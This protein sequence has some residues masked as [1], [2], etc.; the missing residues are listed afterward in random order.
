[1]GKQGVGKTTLVNILGGT[2]RSSNER[3]E[4]SSHTLYRS[5]INCGNY[6]FSLIDT[7]GTDSFTDLS[8]YAFLLR[9]GLT[10]TIMNTIFIVVRYDSRFD[11]MVDSYF[12]VEQLVKHNMDKIIV[13]ISFG[14]QSKNPE[15]SFT[16]ICQLFEEECPNVSNLI[17]YSERSPNIQVANLMYNCISNM[18]A[19]ELDI[20]T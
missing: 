3:Q 5:V 18:P 1:M 10:S 2:E 4:T 9:N 7:C 19:E 14:E 20:R 13:M 17:F 16:E 6:P 8:E 15:R 12:E 11:R